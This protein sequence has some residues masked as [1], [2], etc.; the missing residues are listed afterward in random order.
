MTADPASEPSPDAATL[1]QRAVT[2]LLDHIQ[3][4]PDVGHLLGYGTTSFSLLC[5]AEAAR[6]GVAPAAV[7]ARR[8]VSTARHP[9]RYLLAHE[10]RTFDRAEEA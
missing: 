2:H 8:I 1:A 3:Q 9:R 4:D 6:L 5:D 10:W 7:Q